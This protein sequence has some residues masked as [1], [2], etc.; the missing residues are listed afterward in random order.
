MASSIP[1]NVIVM[2]PDVG[3]YGESIGPVDYGCVRRY[4][5]RRLGTFLWLHGFRDTLRG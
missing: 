5:H 1:D 2:P 3:S 4:R